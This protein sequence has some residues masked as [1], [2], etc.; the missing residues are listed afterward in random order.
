MLKNFIISMRIHTQVSSPCKA[1]VQTQVRYPGITSIRSKPMQDSIRRI[2]KPF[3]TLNYVICWIIPF[4][5]AESS[6]KFSAVIRKYITMPRRNFLFY[7]RTF[8]ITI[9]PLCWISRL[10]HKSTCTIKD[11]HDCIHFRQICTA[12]NQRSFIH[13]RSNQSATDA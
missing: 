6:H 9:R 13:L 2:I 7:K 8:W 4:D 12:N 1:P 3:T 11:R 5:V 10:N